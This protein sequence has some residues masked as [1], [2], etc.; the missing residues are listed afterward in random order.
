MQTAL[1]TSP[2]HEQC[3]ANAHLIAS[4]PEM[5]EA[6]KAIQQGIER[7]KERLGYGLEEQLNQAIAK[8]EGK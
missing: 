4:S 2:S 8:A 6:L 5:Y 7:G 3:T 1:Y